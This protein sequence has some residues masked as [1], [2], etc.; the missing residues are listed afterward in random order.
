MI[1]YKEKKVTITDKEKVSITC[2]KCKKEYLYKDDILEIQEF[3]F[4]RFIGGYGSIFG[5]GDEVDKHICQYCLKEW[6]DSWE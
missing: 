4:L 3:V 5:D 1:K 2:D 6:L